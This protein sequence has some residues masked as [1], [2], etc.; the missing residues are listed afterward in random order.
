MN[1]LMYWDDITDKWLTINELNVDPLRM[2]CEGDK[3]YLRFQSINEGKVYVVIDSVYGE[4]NLITP[5]KV[6]LL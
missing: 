3:R 6:D 4:L 2:L 1:T 5:I